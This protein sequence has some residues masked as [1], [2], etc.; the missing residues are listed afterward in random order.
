MA[1][2]QR[3]VEGAGEA[4]ERARHHHHVGAVAGHRQQ[5]QVHQQPAGERSPAET[6]SE[7]DVRSGKG[8]GW[9]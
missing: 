6:A 2:L 1:G 3:A 4:H 7:A 5:Q 9:H 8:E